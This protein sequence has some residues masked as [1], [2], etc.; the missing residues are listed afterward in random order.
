MYTFRTSRHLDMFLM[1]H[2]WYHQCGSDLFGNWIQ[3]HAA[4]LADDHNM[5]PA[6]P[7][8]LQKCADRCLYH[9]QQISRLLEKMLRVE[10]NHLFRDPWLSFCILDS[11]RI[12]LANESSQSQQIG[13]DSRKEI[14]QLLK[15]NIQALVNTKDILPLASRVVSIWRN[16]VIAI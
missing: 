8:F 12:Q 2:I 3:D 9:A 14:S 1:V 5:P 13:S 10:P 11:T 7:E 16:R 6:T 4:G 15:F